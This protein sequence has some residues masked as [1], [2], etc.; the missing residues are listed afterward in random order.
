[1]EDYRISSEPGYG[2]P[3]NEL[4]WVN[5]SPNAANLAMARCYA[6]TVMLEGTTLSEGRGTTRP[7][8]VIGA[9]DID[10]NNLVTEMR[11]LAPQWLTG[12]LLRTCSFEPTFHK[13]ARTLCHGF[14]IHVDHGA[15]HH[16]NFQP[17]RL[18]ALTFKAIRG[19]YPS[20]DLWRNFAYE[21]VYDKL[22][23]DVINGGSFLREWV[24][25]PSATIEEFEKRMKLDEKSWE[26]ERPE[27][28]LYGR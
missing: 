26:E 10:A 19:L 4:S 8:E 13:H 24:D 1:M 23:I 17:Y 14:Q 18:M 9:P 12:C 11:K 28:F 16:E 6:G 7:L 20:Y 15:Y 22:P 21:Y 2:W 27:F 3:V 5:P 25:R